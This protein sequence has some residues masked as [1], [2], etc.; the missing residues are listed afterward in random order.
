[1]RDEFESVSGHLD[2]MQYTKYACVYAFGVINL[3]IKCT[4]LEVESY[5][6]RSYLHYG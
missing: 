6:N 1:M 2:E 4:G 5:R 3:K